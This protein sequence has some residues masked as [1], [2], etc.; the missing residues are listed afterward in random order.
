MA[1]SSVQSRRRAKCSILRSRALAGLP[2]GDGMFSKRK[3]SLLVSA[4]IGIR[5]TSGEGRVA[6]VIAPLMQSRTTTQNKK[7]RPSSARPESTK[8]QPYAAGH[9]AGLYS[10]DVTMVS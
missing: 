8:A 7:K 2:Y 10:S 1:S 3:R 9:T 5:M 4:H 6:M